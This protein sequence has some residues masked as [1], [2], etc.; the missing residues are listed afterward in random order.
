MAIPALQGGGGL[1]GAT[2]AWHGMSL[3]RAVDL[4]IR[5]TLAAIAV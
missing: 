5:V 1:G 2:M 4:I 3:L